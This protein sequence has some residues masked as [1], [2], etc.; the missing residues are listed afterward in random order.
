PICA[1]TERAY[2]SHSLLMPD[3]ANEE[4]IRS[5]RGQQTLRQDCRE[6]RSAPFCVPASNEFPL[7]LWPGPPK[8]HAHTPPLTTPP[9]CLRR[10]PMRGRTPQKPP[11]TCPASRTPSLHKS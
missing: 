8:R 1:P 4:P 6:A 10:I 9:S 2:G 3:L 11:T 7:P 5:H